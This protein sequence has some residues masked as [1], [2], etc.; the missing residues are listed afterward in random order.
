M[1]D[2]S[3]KS[4]VLMYLA[5]TFVWGVVAA[6]GVLA[7]FAYDLPDVEKAL[8]ATRRPTVTLVAADGAHLLT[9]GD[10]HGLPVH[11]ND[12]PPALPQAIMATE[13]RRYYDHFGLDL[14]GLARATVTNIKAGRVV[15]GG[16][17]ITQQVAKNVFLTPDRTFRRK[18]QEL[19]LALWLEQKFSKDQIFTVYLNRVYLGSGTY[20]VEAASQ[21]YFQ[22][23]ARLLDTWQ[24]AMLAGLLKAPSRYNPISNPKLAKRRTEQVLAN[25][26]AAGYLSKADVAAV[27][28]GHGTIKPV[29]TTRRARYFSDWVLAQVPSYVS[30][31]DRDLTVV[32]TIDRRLQSDGEAAIARA[33]KKGKAFNV[34][35]AALVALTPGG[36]VRALVGGADYGTSQ[37][38]R[39][40]QAIRQP[41]SAFKPLVFLAG[42]EAGMT[43][44]TV[45]EDKALTI[46]DWTPRN[47]SRKFAGP[48]TLQ[49]AL[50]GSINTV[51]VRISRS[52]G[53]EKVIETARRLGVTANLKAIPSLALGT[54]GLTLLELTAAYGTFANG[55]YG[56]WP[57]GIEEIRD[58]KGAVLY[59]RQGSGPGRVI[60]AW[61]AG[62]MNEMLSEAITTGTG[63]QA[64]LKR[65]AAGKT[66]TSQDYRD[67]LFVGYSADLVAGVWMGNDNV[68]PMKRVT[69]GGLPAIA[70]RNFMV[71]AHQKTPP[72]ALPAPGDKPVRPKRAG[73]PEQPKEG[74]FWKSILDMFG[75]TEK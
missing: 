67:A 13:D 46:D 28:S 51:A 71:A 15:Q 9:V 50:A 27:K 62:T 69:G 61:S 40:T 16:S 32:T 65:P 1:S 73:A 42:L 43:P 55:G 31:G 30:V 57:Y 39:V 63:K 75:N 59:R 49:Q 10:I 52:V 47:F 38:N 17:T 58:N 35:Q 68:A 26:V 6:I 21:R 36:A 2:K 22:K 60:D 25:M 19:L 34:G 8:A 41:G 72:R 48:V 29:R 23:P 11:L 44:K 53:Y 66:G 12:V 18:I 70:W 33:L 3:R 24:S 4:R 54:S 14:I 7:F 5:A 64:K 45:I 56:V 37:Y 74:G 20:G